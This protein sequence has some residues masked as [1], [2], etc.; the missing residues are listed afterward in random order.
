MSGRCGGGTSWTSRRGYFSADVVR[1]AARSQ[2]LLEDNG[3]VHSMSPQA[4]RL[5]VLPPTEGSPPSTPRRREPSVHPRL[6]HSLAAHAPSDGLF[7]LA[8]PGT[9]A[10]RLSRPNSEPMRA[11]LRPMLC[12]VAQ[13]AKTIALGHQVFDYDAS[14]MLIFSVDLPVAGQVRRASPSEPYLCFRLDL[15]PFRISELALRVF[16]SGVPRPD[17]PLGLY[18]G[19]VN[20]QIVEAATRLVELM[21][22]PEDARL[23]G[24][25]L[26]DEILIRL[27]RSPVGARVAQIGCDDSGLQRIAKAVA[28]IRANFTQPLRIEALAR[29]AHMS[30]SSF[31]QRFKDVTAMSPLQYQKALRLEQAKR[32]MLGHAMDAKQAAGEVG[33]QSAS[34]FTREYARHFG[35][36][37]KRDIARLRAA[38]P[39]GRS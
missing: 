34:Q 30:A 22:Q 19:D 8:L 15:D 17:N 10:I 6:A 27:L 13:G 18:V 12:L 20:D 16:P 33:Y 5:R 28:E 32:L 36:T 9:F 2:A 1:Q 14:R 11:T 31:H 7:E 37:P 26:V 29:M 25:L 21:S 24:P 3:F 39:I 35:S 23:L 4:N 38:P